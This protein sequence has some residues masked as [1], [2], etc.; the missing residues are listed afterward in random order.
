M[1]SLSGWLKD[2]SRALGREE[3]LFNLGSAMIDGAASHVSSVKFQS[4]YFEAQGAEGF[5][6]LRALMKLAA[7]RGLCTILDAKRGDIAATMRAYGAAA[8]DYFAA[9]ALTV[10][11]WLGTDVIDPLKSWLDAGRGIYVVWTTSNREAARIQDVSVAT[12]E[13]GAVKQTLAGRVF[14]DFDAFAN[15]RGLAGA[16][17]WVFGAT[18]FGSIDLG[19]AG[20]QPR[21]WLMPGVG[22][23]GAD[24]S[25]ALRAFLAK[26]PASLVPISRGIFPGESFDAF[27]SWASVKLETSRKS[28]FWK[29]QLLP[30]G[31][32]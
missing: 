5:A 4:A 20:S 32:S 13:S 14:A 19:P 10:T 7:E 9:D 8:F 29:Q 27:D 25:P 22:A 6:A 30:K 31:G 12:G 23:Q 18:K 16:I 21:A 1:N 3:F 2:Q 15:G 26:N 24:V 28:L 11:P 17:G